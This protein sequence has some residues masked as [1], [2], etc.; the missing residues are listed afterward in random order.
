MKVFSF[1]AGILEFSCTVSRYC[2]V[3]GESGSTMEDAVAFDD[4]ESVAHDLTDCDAELLLRLK[5]SFALLPME[6]MVPDCGAFLAG[7]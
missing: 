3:F 6:L 2:M 5:T 1:G 4:L 7:V